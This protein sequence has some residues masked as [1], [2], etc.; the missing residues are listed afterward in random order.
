MELTGSDINDD[1]SVTQ[2]LADYYRAFSTLDLQAFLPY[3]LE[4]SMVIGPQGVF[5]APT[6]D[7]LA[8]AFSVAV[9]GL[10]A[11]NY[12]RSEL[13]IRCVKTLSATAALVNGVALRY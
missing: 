5:P 4:P 7:V 6:H 13:V 11:R 12:G 2:T 1:S 9:E 10:R 3:F 8:L